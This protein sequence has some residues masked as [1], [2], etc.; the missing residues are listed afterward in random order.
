LFIIFNFI[1]YLLTL[2]IIFYKKIKN[3]STLIFINIIYTIFKKV[4][5]K[6]NRGHRS[7][8]TTNIHHIY[9]YI[10]IIVEIEKVLN[11]NYVEI[12]KRLK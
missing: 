8:N 4:K 3:L 1:Y 9:I 6:K 12:M 5:E 10:Y 11:E 7:Y 2:D